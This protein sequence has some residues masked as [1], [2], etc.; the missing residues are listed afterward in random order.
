MFSKILYPETYE[1]FCAEEI[2]YAV[3]LNDPVV[4]LATL[5]IPSPRSTFALVFP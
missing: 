5:D 4:V 3:G 2:G 1:G